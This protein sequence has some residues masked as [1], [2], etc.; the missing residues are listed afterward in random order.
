MRDIR[1]LREVVCREGE[2]KVVEKR[3]VARSR[4]ELMA[5]EED[6]EW[7]EVGGR[8]KRIGV[9][10]RRGEGSGWRRGRRG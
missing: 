10:E 7:R 2:G 5:E 4:W 1:K 8:E 9:Q 6:E 3:R